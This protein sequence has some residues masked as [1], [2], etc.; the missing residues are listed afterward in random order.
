[1][2]SRSIGASSNTSVD[3]QGDPESSEGVADA[4]VAYQATIAR[5]VFRRHEVSIL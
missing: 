2:A 4:K 1:M 3:Q 5:A